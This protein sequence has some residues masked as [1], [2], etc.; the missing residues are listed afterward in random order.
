MDQKRNSKQLKE[1]NAN[2]LLHSSLVKANKSTLLEALK[3]GCNLKTLSKHGDPPIVAAAG[4]D[5]YTS[6]DT[7]TGRDKMLEIFDILLEH[8]ECDVNGRGAGGDT[9]LHRAVGVRALNRIRYLLE[10]GCDVDIR[11]SK[12]QTAL[13]AAIGFV[14][15][16]ELLLMYRPLLDV[17]DVDGDTPLFHAMMSESPSSLEALKML[18]NA[19]CDVSC[20]SQDGKTALTVTL[21]SN[22]RLP[23]SDQ[24]GTSLT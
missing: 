4:I 11:D 5:P 7:K 2:L 13:F 24:V 19:K 1:Q 3:L 18:T 16:L 12:G 15:G 21:E 8:R 6:H 9:A 10:R 20:V 23:R 14:E 22:G 17:Y